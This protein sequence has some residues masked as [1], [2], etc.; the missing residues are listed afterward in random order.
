MKS[1]LTV[2]GAALGRWKRADVTSTVGAGVLGGGIALLL[3]PYMR[4]YA[5][6]LLIVGALLHGWG[7]FDRHRIERASGAAS[8]P[9]VRALYW[10]CWVAL[11]VLAVAVV[12]ANV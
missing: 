5:V 12:A 10:T 6:G 3:A 4:P 2:S 11:F 1:N 9:W 8:M 7:M